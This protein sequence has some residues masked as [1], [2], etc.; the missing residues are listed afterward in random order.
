MFVE[1]GQILDLGYNPNGLSSADKNSFWKQ[2]AN[3]PLQDT[4]FR[5]CPTATLS[6]NIFKHIHYME[7]IT[8]IPLQKELGEKKW[9][10]WL[11]IWPLR[12]IESF[13]T[14]YLPE[15]L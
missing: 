10:K 1:L 5:N 12:Q 13:L 7:E 2:H 4:G 15:F 8:S 14:S 9:E 11:V 3:K 6:V